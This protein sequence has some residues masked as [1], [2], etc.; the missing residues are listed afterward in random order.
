MVIMESLGQCEGSYAVSR[1][2]LELFWDLQDS[3]RV[4]MGSPGQ[5]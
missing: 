1:T 4:V 2:V 5:C 3:V